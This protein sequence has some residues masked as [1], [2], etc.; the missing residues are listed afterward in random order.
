[1]CGRD[2]DTLNDKNFDFP[3]LLAN[4]KKLAIKDEPDRLNAA[5]ELA[6][7]GKGREHLIS[8][9]SDKEECVRR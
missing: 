5:F 2:I 3:A 6:K 9:M 8:H 7:S 4:F 1:M